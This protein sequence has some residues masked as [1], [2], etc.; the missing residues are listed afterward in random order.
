M[1]IQQAL[2]VKSGDTIVNRIDGSHMLVVTVYKT[3]DNYR[4][5]LCVYPKRGFGFCLSES[6]IHDWH[7]DS[8]LGDIEYDVIPDYESLLGKQVAWFAICDIGQIINKAEQKVMAA[9]PKA[10]CA[11]CNSEKLIKTDFYTRLCM[12][13]YEPGDEKLL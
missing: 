13:C 12:D 11:T 3:S 5:F 1:E 9:K 8:R 7:N 10:H 2:Q 6:D 4:E